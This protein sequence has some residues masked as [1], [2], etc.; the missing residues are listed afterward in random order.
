MQPDGKMFI[1]DLG[2]GY[3]SYFPAGFLHSIQGL[4]GDGT[5]FLR[6]FDQGDVSKDDAFL[7]SEFLAHT[8]PAGKPTIRRAPQGKMPV[9]SR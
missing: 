5:E 1:D 4:D 9:L 6:V 3:L 8:P 2:P 7:L